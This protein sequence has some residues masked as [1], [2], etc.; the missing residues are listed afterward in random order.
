MFRCWKKRGDYEG[1]RC[2]KGRIRLGISE[3]LAVTPSS[4]WRGLLLTSERSFLGRSTEAR[5]TWE[6]VEW[7]WG[8]GTGWQWGERGGSRGEVPMR[9]DRQLWTF[10]EEEDTGSVWWM[11]EWRG[12][13]DKTAWICWEVESPRTKCGETGRDE[14]GCPGGRGPMKMGD[15]EVI[16]EGRKLAVGEGKGFGRTGRTQSD[17]P[18]SSHC[19]SQGPCFS[20]AALAT[21]GDHT[22]LQDGVAFQLGRF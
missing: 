20:S 7:G 12:R 22:D 21:G 16:T 11:T 10:E 19:K 1:E 14:T 4:C 8:E 9:G 17:L 13:H 3:R 15:A 2:S 6:R 18:V 5:Q